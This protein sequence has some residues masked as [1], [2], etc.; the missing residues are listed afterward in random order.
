LAIVPEMFL[1]QY[2]I[3][4]AHGRMADDKRFNIQFDYQASIIQ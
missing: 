4:S 3:L 2:D 1:G